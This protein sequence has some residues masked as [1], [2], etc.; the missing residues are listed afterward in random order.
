MSWSMQQSDREN[1]EMVQLKEEIADALREWENANRY[2]NY[3]IGKEQI[4]HAIFAIITAEKRYGML[5]SRAKR[6]HVE[7]PEWKEEL[8]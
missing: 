6:L 3:S 7:W 1:K 5:M 8:R 4:D 2:F